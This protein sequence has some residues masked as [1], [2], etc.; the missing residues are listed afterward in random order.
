MK[1]KQQVVICDECEEENVFSD[2]P[3][4][5]GHPLHGWVTVNIM[6]GSTML[7]NLNKKSNFDFCGIECMV[8]HFSQR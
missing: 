2:E 4:C 3:C 1:K 8:K 7:S 6:N 5:G